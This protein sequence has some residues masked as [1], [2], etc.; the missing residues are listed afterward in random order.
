MA[1]YLERLLTIT[2]LIAKGFIQNKV[3]LVRHLELSYD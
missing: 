1:Y 3:E 2:T